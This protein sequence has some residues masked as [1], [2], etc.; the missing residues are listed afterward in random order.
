M[1]GIVGWI[2]SNGHGIDPDL[3]VQ[4]RDMLRHR[5]PDDQGVW[6]SQDRRVGLGHRRLAIIDLSALGHQPMSNVRGDLH[7]VFNGEIYNFRELRH[8]LEGLG[9]VFQ[10]SSDT[11][12]ILEAYDAW[13]EDAFR[14]FNGMFGLALYDA[15]RE[16]IILARDRAGEK[17]L[18]YGGLNGGLLFGSELKALLAH[19]DVPRTLD[20]ESLNF[21]LAYGYV[22]R[23]RCI[24]R[25]LRK[26]PPGHLLTYDL[27]SSTA[28]I[29][30]FWTLPLPADVARSEE[31]LVEE[32]EA[33][34]A[35]SVRLRLTASDVPVSVLLSGGL[36]SSL[37]TALAARVSPHPVQSFV[38]TFP[39][40]GRF[41][42]GPHARLVAEWLGTNHTELPLE[43]ATADVLSELAWHFDEPIADSSMV[44]TFLLSRLIRQHAK[45]ALGGD[46]GDELFGGY[47]HY[48]YIA[49]HARLRNFVPAHVRRGVATVGGWLPPGTRSRNHLIGLADGLPQAIAH[50]NVYFDARSR[51]HLLTAELQRQ[52]TL[53]TPEA[54]KAELCN[55]GTALANA[56]SVDFQTY[57]PDDLLVKVDRASMATALEVRAPWLDHRLVEFAFRDVPDR[58]RV[59]DNARKILPRGLA[60]RVLP[61]T[62]DSQR[63]QGFS[64]PL[65]TW[66]K[67]RWGPVLREILAGVDAQVFRRPFVS[68]LLDHQDKGRTNTQRLYALAFFELWRREYRVELS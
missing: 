16:R 11:E 33:L 8:R 56:M 68:A 40:H 3:L 48:N 2:A 66:F 43:P 60:R 14:S 29:A 19:S 55:R 15:R 5:G 47:P 1:C 50:V 12:V 27:R 13:G 53:G 36:D 9:R 35:D 10:T 32:L 52:L 63:K 37:V 28:A 49:W 22:P 44:P 58:F 59:T 24:L 51:K 34:L 65:D 54:F 61:E 23:E 26:L 42:E 20:P 64:M 17:P 67:D 57:L 30:P 4:M 7:V 46:G 39:G 25:G 21:Y 6:W 31:D 41:D 45:V 38:V 62:F 18:F